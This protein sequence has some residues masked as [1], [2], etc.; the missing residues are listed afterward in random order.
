[1]YYQNFKKKPVS[2]RGNR[3]FADITIISVIIKMRV[4]K[5]LAIGNWHLA[6]WK[7]IK[8]LISRIEVLV[9]SNDLPVASCQPL[10]A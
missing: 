9:G 5:Q 6:D 8:E 7:K 2:D 4:K 10:K 1:M 3:K